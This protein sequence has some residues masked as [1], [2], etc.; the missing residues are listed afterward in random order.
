MTKRK[1]AK[2]QNDLNNITKKTDDRATRQEFTISRMFTK[3]IIIV[4]SCIFLVRGKLKI[5]QIYNI[6]FIFILQS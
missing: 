3:I 5:Q 6:E 2:G 1:M 4:V